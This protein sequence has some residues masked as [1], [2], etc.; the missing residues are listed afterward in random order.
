MTASSVSPKAIELLRDRIKRAVKAADRTL[1]VMEVC[2]THTMAVFRSGIRSILPPE[3]KLISGPGCPVCVTPA[4]FVDRAIAIARTHEATITTYGDMMRVPGSLGSLIAERAAGADVRDVYSSS[5]AL[6]I[7]RA[8]D[9]KDVVFLGVGFETTTP[10]IAATILAAERDGIS[11]F[12]VLAA[13]KLVPPA[14]EAVL[15]GGA[16]IDGFL[17]PGHVSVIIG[18]DAYGPVVRDHQVP[19]V[20]AGFEPHEILLAL[21]M[22]AE[23]VAA[24]RAEIESAY[25]HAVTSEGNPAARAI[26]GEA[27]RPADAEWRGLGTI[28][29]S[30][31]VLVDR[32]A[33]MDA[34]R[35]L[36]VNVPESRDPAG[37]RCGEVLSGLTEPSECGMFGAACTPD[38]PIGP[39]MVSSEGTCAAHFKY[40]LDARGLASIEPLS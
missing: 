4:S 39:C 21:A 17:C 13:P 32:F 37:C 23:Q 40:G 28:P 30:G 1:R 27:F 24:G 12:S 15:A 38:T 33:S 35:R 8:N 31:L 29:K 16:K 22:L 5:D 2:G 11:N 18:S 19:C 20:V 10:G 25:G 3:L 34:A 9:G 36:E 14:L 6:D 7:A 26:M